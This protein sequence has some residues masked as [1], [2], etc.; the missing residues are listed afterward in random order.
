M[1]DEPQC[2]DYR[3]MGVP[4]LSFHGVHP[5]LPQYENFR[6]QL[7]VLYN[8]VYSAGPSRQPDSSFYLMFNFHNTAHDFDLPKAPGGGRWHVVLDTS[9][10]AADPWFAPG[11]E[12]EAEKGLWPVKPHS[13][14]ILVEKENK[15]ERRQKRRKR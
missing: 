11:E 2:R 1:A 8:G 6:R 7:G 3:S 4:D 15:N 12:P 5:W 10:E 9:S 13:I 14:V